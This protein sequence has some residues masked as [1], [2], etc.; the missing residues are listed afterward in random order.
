MTSYI[1]D[2]DVHTINAII[3]YIEKIPFLTM[4]GYHTNPLIAIDEINKG[5]KPD[6]VFLDVEM[7][8]LSG[9]DVI[10][11][12][13]K[14]IIVVF[15]T[16]HSKYA[17]Q[18][19]QKDVV[20]FLLKPFTFEQLLKCANKIRGKV[21]SNPNEQKEINKAQLFVNP[22][23]KG[24]IIQI[25][26]GEVTHI[27]ANE[28]SACINLINEKVVINMS[29]KKIQERLSEKAFIRV[30]RAYIVNIRAIKTL[31]A[32]QITLKNGIQIPLGEAYRNGVMKLLQ[33]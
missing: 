31:E 16:S 26:L 18:A 22:G 4:I 9:L 25:E 17:L 11:M 10:D 15:I 28:H 6:I 1:I 29:I 20:D 27:E 8:E 2:D 5:K 12:L 33:G 3:K 24:K 30:H 21:L 14:S 7:P 19:F 32:N 13:D 23:L